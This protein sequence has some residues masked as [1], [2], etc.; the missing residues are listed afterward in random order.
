MPI[1]A[2]TEE[3]FDTVLSEN[4]Y[5]LVDFW[6]E[7]CQPC[8]QLNEV[9]EQLAEARPELVIA[10]ID[11]AKEK[12]LAEE[13]HVKSVPRLLLVRGKVILSDEGGLMSLASL[14]DLVDRA[15]A[16]TEEQLDDLRKQAEGSAE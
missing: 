11:I 12:T 9:L 8:L 5:V 15:Q 14:E 3:T 16:I 10:K 1:V 6:A 2:V 13:F 7:W 4:E